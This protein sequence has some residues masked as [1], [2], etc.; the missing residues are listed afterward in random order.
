[1]NFDRGSLGDLARFQC[2]W[3]GVLRT[4]GR[5]IDALGERVWVGKVV[6]AFWLSAPAEAG[7]MNCEAWALPVNKQIDGRSSARTMLN[8]HY[9]H[10]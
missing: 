4:S 10:P 9:I 7:N 2:V 3:L 8:N 1:M 6:F 5:M